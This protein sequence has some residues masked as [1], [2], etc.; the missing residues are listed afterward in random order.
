MVWIVQADLWAWP[1]CSI[2]LWIWIQTDLLWLFSPSEL[3]WFNTYHLPNNQQREKYKQLSCDCAILSCTL[4]NGSVMY[5]WGMLF[6]VLLFPLPMIFFL[7]CTKLFSYWHDAIATGMACSS[8]V[9]Y[10]V[11]SCTSRCHYRTDILGVLQLSTTK[12]YVK[13]AIPYM[14]RKCLSY[15]DIIT[16]K[17][18]YN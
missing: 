8:D 2:A 11:R 7:F 15:L 16:V 14:N 3:L 12:F 18:M 17:Q 4:K 5:E 10:L 6:T 1:V 13:P 9:Q